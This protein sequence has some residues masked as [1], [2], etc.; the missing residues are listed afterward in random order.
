MTPALLMPAA[1]SLTDGTAAAAP[2]PEPRQR[3]FTT[4]ARA[5][6]VPEQVVLGVS[7][8]ESRWDANAG[9][10]STAAGYGPM[11][12]TDARSALAGQAPA[13]QAR[14]GDPAAGPPEDPRGD[15]ARPLPATRTTARPASTAT[16]PAGSQTLERAAGLTGLSAGRLRTD[17]AANIRGGAALL[18][19]YQRELGAPSSTDP[20][21]WYGAV[22]RYSGATVAAAA[23][24][25]ADEVFTTIRTGAR[26]VTDDGQQ[27]ELT[28]VPGVRPRTAALSRLGLRADGAGATDCPAGLPCEWIPAP[29][30]QLSADPA[31]YGNHDLG[32]RP[33]SQ[34]IDYIVV[35]DTESSY[36]STINGVQDP[37]YVSWQY[38][39]RSAD[40]HVAQHVR[41]KNVAWQAGNWYVNAKSI[42]IE[43]EGYLAQG[44]SWYTE[45][46]YRSSARLVRYLAARFDVPLDREHIL[47]HDNVPGPTPGTVEGMHTDPGP[48]WDWAHYFRLLGSPLRAT[49]GARSD[50]VMILPDYAQNV[51]PYT[52]CDE[53]TPSAP[54]PAHGGGSV[55]LRTEPRADAP[56]VKDVGKHPT[57]G[58]E[59]TTSVYDHSARAST[60]QRYAVADRQG[61]W[62]AIWYLGQKAWFHNP[63]QRPTAVGARGLVVTPKPGVASVP[64]YGRAYPEKEAYPAGIPV[65]ALAPLQYTFAAGQRYTVGATQTGEYYY[66]TTFDEADHAVVRGSLKYYEI[67]F[68]HRVFFVKADD[69][70][71][72]KAS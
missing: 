67:Q 66:A 54:C 31:D 11:H 3:S 33:K 63:P 45:V 58:G 12:L 47:G 41:P 68:G 26:R 32:Q 4:A 18:A 64:V 27:V 50:M 52:G 44:G 10:P 30:Q 14:S 65:Q 22:A 29:Y 70:Q 20:A 24:F 8:L 51:V 15:D 28:A 48:Y 16:N 49:A 2:V 23:R 55:M 57:T 59:A 35:H 38:T 40:G 36:T 19:A 5:Y 62:T 37:T 25:F 43:H 17:P 13:G 7:Y 69:V 34:K 72:I 56:L 9:R 42:G 71:V 6:G 61:D 60:G 21:D 46:M 39:I 1:L 53:A